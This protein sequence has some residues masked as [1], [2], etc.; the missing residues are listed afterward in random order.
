MGSGDLGTLWITGGKD[1]LQDENWKVNKD[2]IKTVKYRDIYDDECICDKENGHNR[3][4]IWKHNGVFNDCG[5]A[6]DKAQGTCVN[7]KA[8]EICT[9]MDSV[10][11]TG[12][13]SDLLTST[14]NSDK[15]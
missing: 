14:T 10:S 12:T 15:C 6:T 8:V 11:D 7:Y 5:N 3:N 2:E 4:S 1:I 13:H 9:E